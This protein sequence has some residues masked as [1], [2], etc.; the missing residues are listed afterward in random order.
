MDGVVAPSS[1]Q[2]LK[3]EVIAVFGERMPRP[4][5]QIK[6]SPSVEKKLLAGTGV[7]F[8]LGAVES[9]PASSLQPCTLSV[10]LLMPLMWKLTHDALEDAAE[11][12][13]KPCAT[14]SF[15]I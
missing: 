14:E 13:H 12:L 5:G 3:E 11:N 1:P 7:L 4:R 6:W 15:Q 8:E 9:I 10:Q 2:L